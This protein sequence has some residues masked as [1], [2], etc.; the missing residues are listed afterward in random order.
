MDGTVY[1]TQLKSYNY[2]E[3][4]EAGINDIWRKNIFDFS[5]KCQDIAY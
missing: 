1:D 4:Y 3:F 5:V 2:S